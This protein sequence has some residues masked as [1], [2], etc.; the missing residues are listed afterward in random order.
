VKKLALAFVLMPLPA[1]A[2]SFATDHLRVTQATEA[3]VACTEQDKGPSSPGYGKC[4]NTYLMS[5]Y[6]WQVGT[7]PDGSLAVY[8]YRY[9]APQHF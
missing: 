3:R 2:S 9:Q 4:I 5:H 6:R 7:N 1:F 8:F